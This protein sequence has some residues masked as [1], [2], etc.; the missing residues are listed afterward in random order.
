MGK[1]CW[2]KAM[3]EM[4]L[5]PRKKEKIPLPIGKNHGGSVRSLPAG[6]P[7]PSSAAR[8]WPVT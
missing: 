7:A 3:Q 8:G 5:N 2:Y 6:L 4:L 1:S